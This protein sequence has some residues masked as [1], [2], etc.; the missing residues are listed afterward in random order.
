MRGRA[1]M[2]ERMCVGEGV[3][4]K[5]GTKKH[6]CHVIDAEYCFGKG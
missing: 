3:H 4:D 5:I 2:Q 6:A 1:H